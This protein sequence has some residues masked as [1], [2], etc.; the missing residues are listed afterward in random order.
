MG[1]NLNLGILL[2]LFLIFFNCTKEVEDP[3]KEIDQLIE[4]EKFDI[5]KERI[6]WKLSSVRENDIV[7]SEKSGSQKRIV[8]VSND[9]NRIV[10]IQDKNIVFRDL[11]NPLVKS[12]VFPQ[13]AVGLS[14]SAEAEH[15]MVLFPLPNSAGCRMIAMSLVEN[16]NSFVSSSFV[17]CANQGGITSD[18]SLIYF[19]IDDSLYLETTS[20]PKV[21]KMI[22]DKKNFEYPFSNIKKKYYI[23]PIGKT[24]LIIYGNAGLYVMQWF[25]PKKNTLTKLADDLASPN[26]YYGNGKNLY[27][28]A[29]T[30]G[31]LKWKELRFSFYGKP[32]LQPGLDIGLSEVNSWP[33]SSQNGF[34]G[35]SNGQLF[36]WGG[37]EKK[38]NIPLFTKEFWVLARDQIVYE[39]KEG[40]LT[41][42][43]LNFSDDDW[44]LLDLYKMVRTKKEN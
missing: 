23:Y 34:L 7:L 27:L 22:L 31:E 8:R 29:G 9:R 21:S 36:L 10:W 26:L 40:R 30:I 35:T 12:L 20:E 38:K 13:T 33:L 39:D 25:D 17:S 14:V 6:K 42:T 4:N 32:S 44:K 28:I 18:G 2:F 3:L 19:F 11:A 43:H 16:R 1:G 15:A 24:F 37:G 41:L 5:A